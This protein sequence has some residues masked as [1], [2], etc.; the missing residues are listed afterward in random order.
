MID[1]F[2]L[3]SHEILNILLDLIQLHQ[4][5]KHVHDLLLG[6]QFIEE[7]VRRRLECLPLAIG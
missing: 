6:V 3:A 5:A 4:E 2:I 1:V 7:H